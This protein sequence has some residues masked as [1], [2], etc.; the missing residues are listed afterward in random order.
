MQV[1][2]QNF[3]ELGTAGAIVPACQMVQQ[4]GSRSLAAS[5]A[6]PPST[7]WGWGGPE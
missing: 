3:S 2:W 6:V 4:V 1:N 7:E 5:Q